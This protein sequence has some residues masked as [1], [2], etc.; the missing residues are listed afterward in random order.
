MDSKVLIIG[1][2][3]FIG[4]YLI[5]EFQSDNVVFT[6]KNTLIEGGVYFDAISMDLDEIISEDDNYKIA[7]ILLGETRPDKCINSVE[8]SRE[9]NVI[10]IVR[11]LDQLYQYGIKPLFISSEFVYDGLS[12][13]YK[14]DGEV[15]PIILYGKQKLEVERYIKSKFNDYLIFRL[16]KTYSVNQDDNTFFTN[17]LQGINDGNK[18]YC[19]TDQK[20]SPIYVDDVVD[21]IYKSVSLNLSGIF[22]LGGPVGY[23]RV[24]LL[25][26]IIEARSKYVDDLAEYMPCLTS[27]LEVKEKWP[28][29]VSMNT[30][31]IMDIFSNRSWFSPEVACKQICD[32][33]YKGS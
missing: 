23:L 9:L 8:M 26:M 31:K 28:L 10:S 7:I 25:K 19:A 24:D 27:E 32:S 33:L 22:N 4:Q 18:I 12:G 21:I 6:Y 5:K 15:D 13:S 29:D 14:E 11:I 2:S 17:W 16:A 20:F 3:S 30:K 1:G